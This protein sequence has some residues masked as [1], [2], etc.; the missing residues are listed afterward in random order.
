MTETA[1]SRNFEKGVPDGLKRLD[2]LRI[3]C[4]EG[5]KCGERKKSKAR[6]D[7]MDV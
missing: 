1:S 4:I 5:E 6:N 7:K 3:D 2:M